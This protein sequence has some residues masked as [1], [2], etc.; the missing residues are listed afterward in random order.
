MADINDIQ[1]LAKTLNLMNIA[2][3]VIDISDEKMSN[4]DYLY[5]ILSEEVKIRNENKINHLHKNAKLPNKK[6]DYTKITQGLK[7]QLNQIKQF[8][9]TSNKQNIFIVG[10]CCSGKTS[11]AV[12][13]SRNAI[14]RGTSVYYT[15]LDDF[16]V[17]IKTKKKAWN[18]ALESDMLTIDDFFY[19]EPSEEELV[20]VYK[21]MMFLI[22]TRSIIIITNR[23][24]SNWKEMKVDKHLVE[25]LQDRML[26]NAQIITLRSEK[27]KE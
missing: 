19:I 23:K 16:L 15:T 14:D 21:T 25:T 2:K 20:L 26:H 11:L 8:D 24:L 17:S 22:E 3:G 6:F 13:I 10:E 12:E 4:K 27:S 7:W 5:H 9:F 18:R 1:V